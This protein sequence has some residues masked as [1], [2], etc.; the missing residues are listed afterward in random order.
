MKKVIFVFGIVVLLAF[1]GCKV[2]DKLTQFHIKYDTEVVIP[3]T[4]GVNLPFDIPTPDIATNSNS[5]FQVHNT[6]KN[7]IDIINLTKMDLTIA[8]PSTANF[9][10]LKDIEIYMSTSSL[11]KV[12][13]AW[14]YNIPKAGL[15]TISLEVSNANL[16]QYIISDTIKLQTKVTTRELISRQIKINVHSDFFVN[17]KILGI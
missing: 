6:H 2:L 13:I 1:S 7:L 16:K 3:A 11:P 8:S 15:K 9:N 5:E 14:L 4:L 12:K 17:A 10:F